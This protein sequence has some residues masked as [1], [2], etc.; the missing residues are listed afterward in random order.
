MTH[1]SNGIFKAL[2]TLVGIVKAFGKHQVSIDAA[3]GAEGWMCTRDGRCGGGHA[4]AEI[5]GWA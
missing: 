2:E 1:I 5:Y 4:C 3:C